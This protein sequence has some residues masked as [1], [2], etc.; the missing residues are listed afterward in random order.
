M[1]PL[2]TMALA[3][4][5]NAVD[6][7]I[8]VAREPAPILFYF[9]N[10][11][12]AASFQVRD[13]SGAVRPEALA[14][15]SHFARCWRTDRE[16]PLH[17]RLVEIVAQTAQ[18]FDAIEVEVISGYRAPPYGAPHS[19]H[20]VGHAMD[21]HVPGVPT[22]KVAQWVWQNFR[23]VG[24]GYYPRQDFVH[25]DVRADDVRWVDRARH[26]ESAHAHFF[27][28]PADEPLPAEAPRLAYDAAQK[29]LVVAGVTDLRGISGGRL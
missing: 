4:V 23:Q 3:L 7:A 20:F 16:R 28:R 9:Q 10:R 5:S 17:P 13:E 14:Q 27:G 26:G 15:L 6:F 8:T 18:H 21:L 2:L 22:R 24:V 1:H 12:Q 19:K 29:T 25:V 11:H